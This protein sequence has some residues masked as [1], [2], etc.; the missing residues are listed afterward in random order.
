MD[1]KDIKKEYIALKDLEIYKLSRE[2]SKNAWEI[3]RNLSFE[4]KKI[5]GEQFIR[6]IDSI[7]AN[8]AEGHGRFHYLDRVKFCYNA[9]GSLEESLNWTEIMMARNIGK[10]AILE[11]ILK[12]LK[13]EEIKLNNYISSIY[14]SKEKK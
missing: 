6:A 14:R 7:S 5:I 9:R 3:Y 4:E 8:I 10:N 11:I 1:I 13:E 2:I 12:L